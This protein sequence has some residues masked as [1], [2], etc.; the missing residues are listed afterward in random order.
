M[1]VDGQP[2]GHGKKTLNDG[3]MYEGGWKQGRFHG[4]GTLTISDKSA[5]SLSQ[6][7]MGNSIVKT[8]DSDEKTREDETSKG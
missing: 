7:S 4:Q 8:G 6:N 5:N 3:T 2:H 1:W